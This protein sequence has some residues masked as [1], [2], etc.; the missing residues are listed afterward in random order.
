MTMPA[1]SR[2]VFIG[3]ALIMISAPALAVG[4]SPVPESGLAHFSSASFESVLAR[5]LEEF[6]GNH[7]GGYI[8]LFQA[9]TQSKDEREKVRLIDEFQEAF[10][11][12]QGVYEGS[13]GR[14]VMA[15]RRPHEP[16]TM[17]FVLF[18]GAVPTIS[19][20]ALMHH[21]CA[22]DRQAR[23]I[24]KGVDRHLEKCGDVPTLTIFYRDA[25]ARPTE[26]TVEFLSKVASDRIRWR[27][28]SVPKSRSEWL[29]NELSIEL[30]AL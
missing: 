15:R 28:H 24:G 27:N 29:V 30:R 22:N 11:V 14:Y 8:F 18:Q 3:S 20:A 2:R 6:F 25:R 10:G 4:I 13:D 17:A 26:E 12:P 16:R 21:N 5:N 23:F 19:A 9:N 1:S 7:K